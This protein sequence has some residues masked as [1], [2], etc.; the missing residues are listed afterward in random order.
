MMISAPTVLLTEDTKT[1]QNVF[2]ETP[3]PTKK[4]YNITPVWASFILHLPRL[5]P[6]S[7]PQVNEII[8]NSDRKLNSL[9]VPAEV[10]HCCCYCCFWRGGFWGCSAL[11]RT[12]RVLKSAMR[13]KIVTQRQ[14]RMKPRLGSDLESHNTPQLVVPADLGRFDGLNSAFV[15]SRNF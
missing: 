6:R 11:L 2:L 13:L 10:G 3:V 8:R 1:S 7:V 9:Q 14:R 12:K 5:P 4:R 15:R